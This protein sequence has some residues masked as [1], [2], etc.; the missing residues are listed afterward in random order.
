MAVHSPCGIFDMSTLP[1]QS[2]PLR[3]FWRL[4]SPIRVAEVAT[5]HMIINAAGIASAYKLLTGEMGGSVN[6]FNAGYRRICDRPSRATPARRA[7][8]N[9]IR[10][11]TSSTKKGGR[12][13]EL[14]G[15]LPAGTRFPFSTVL[16]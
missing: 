2:G 8:K 5:F 4:F 6:L 7:K 11:A 12:F 16:A 13:Q 14:S 9:G 3:V 1:R 10:E 15:G